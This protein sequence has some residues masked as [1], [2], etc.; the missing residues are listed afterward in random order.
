MTPLYYILLGALL[1]TISCWLA[2][3]VRRGL[4]ELGDDM[5]RQAA[6]SRRLTAKQRTDG[7]GGE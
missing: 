5:G 7:G 6:R 3:G 2:W 4:P 1:A